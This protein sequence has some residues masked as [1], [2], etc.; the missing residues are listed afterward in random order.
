MSANA[1]RS[2]GPRR[3]VAFLPLAG[4]AVV[5]AL[6]FARLYAGDPSRLPSALIG[7]S[8]PPFTLSGLDGSPPLTDA[9]LR[10]G[11][12]SVVNVFGSWCQPCHLE[13]PYL[14][15]LAADQELKGKG[16]AVYGVAQKDSAEN[17]RRFLGAVGNPYARVGL[18]P[19]GRAGI[20]WGVYG[21]PETF[22]V[23]GDGTIVYKIV[24]P[25]TAETA[26]SELKPQILK[27]IGASGP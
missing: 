17:V 3:W 15:A 10:Q 7:Q 16:V 2:E 13:H 26:A 5:A 14:M 18:D 20:D 4:F 9:D 23:R 6:L 21:V 8:A 24:G 25:I 1:D 27:A 11:H 22:I 12:V 19:N